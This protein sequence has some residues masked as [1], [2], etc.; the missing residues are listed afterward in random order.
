M[1]C[2]AMAWHGIFMPSTAPRRASLCLAGQGMR[3]S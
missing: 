3:S 1:R 2:R